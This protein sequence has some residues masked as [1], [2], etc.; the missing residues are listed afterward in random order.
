[1][2]LL[3]GLMFARRKVTRLILILRVI[4]TRVTWTLLV[5]PPRVKL[6]NCRKTVAMFL[7]MRL[8]LRKRPCRSMS[9]SRRPLDNAEELD[10]RSEP[11]PSAA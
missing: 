10:K 1:M 6:T 9:D 2:Q 7:R 11:A 3:I 5:L 8:N 4:L